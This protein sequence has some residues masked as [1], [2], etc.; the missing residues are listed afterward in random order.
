LFPIVAGA[1]ALLVTASALPLPI[2]IDSG[3][4]D[5][6]S[7]LGVRLPSARSQT[8]AVWD[9]AQHAYVFGGVGTAKLDEIVR[10]T[11]ATESVATLS[12]ELPTPRSY[13]TSVWA[14]SVAY[15]FGGFD[16]TYLDQIVRFDP[17]TETVT[18]LPA[19]L[20]R[21]LC[22]TSAVWSGSSVYLFGGSWGVPAESTVVRFT[23]AT[24]QVTTMGARLPTDRTLT[25]AVWDGAY[26]YVFGGISEEGNKLGEVVRYDPATDT[27]RVMAGLLPTPRRFTAAAWDGYDAI[28]LGGDD[29]TT[30]RQAV[31]YSPSADRTTVMSRALPTARL[32]MSVVWSGTAAYAFGGELT[33]KT[34]EIVKY[35]LEPGAP[36]GVSAAAGPAREKI[37]VSW[38]A[39]ARNT[40]SG[41]IMSYRVYR[42]L[43]SGDETFLTEVPGN[44]FIDTG[45]ANCG[46]RFY[47]V[48]A[49]GA[50]GVG[51][52]SPSVSSSSCTPPSAPRSFAATGG[53]RQ[54][55][56]TWSAPARDGY[57]DIL[58]YSIYR[59][60]NF[61]TL[62]NATT[63]SHLDAGLPD[64]TTYT[65]AVRA[66][67]MMGLGSAASASASTFAKPSEP[68]N[69]KASF[70]PA[71]GEVTLTWAA[72]SSN[73]GTPVTN[74]RIYRG[75]ATGS[76]T[77]VAE[78]GN[79]LTYVD[80]VPG[81]GLYSYKVS[82][83]NIVGE[84]PL[85]ERALAPG[86]RAP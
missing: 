55:G 60:G 74:Y 48:Q 33:S 35:T 82:A 2:L 64:G 37:M 8:S 15:V 59:N 84:G 19:R 24:G 62:V 69:L 76:E 12:A 72:P 40:Y 66:K 13:T 23:P 30:L 6:M 78:I 22:C 63:F 49:V 25:S 5:T 27:V 11:P 65:Y 73:G 81:P 17:A 28:L 29:N 46:V 26:A 42:G 58:S 32:G 70:G 18:V 67:N 1:L 20:P 77:F 51:P 4:A 14:G 9:G 36:L 80:V 56:L 79:V 52:L 50:L 7:P 83:V 47:R 68:R 31:K 41:P 21:A 45:I 16:G 43:A 3:A 75:P 39:P 85:S 10:F 44:P 38:G 54:I 53:L 86:I 57:T 71:L 61:L 34:N